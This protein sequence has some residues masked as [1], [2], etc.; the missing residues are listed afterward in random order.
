MAGVPVEDLPHVDEHDVVVHAGVEDVWRAVV[1][2]FS[3]ALTSPQ[4]RAAARVLGCVPA[5]ASGWP[6][7][8]G[9]VPGF[10]VAAAEP[11][12]LLVLRGRHRFSRYGIVVRVEPHTD[13]ARCRLES[14]A[15]F[16]GPHGRA[17]RALVIGSGGHLLAVRRLLR[18]VARDA[19]QQPRT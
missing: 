3:S 1:E 12:R 17:Y 16:P 6:G 15:A 4:A 9:T 13:G 5:D 19:E 14:R 10:A 7:P 11:P 2:S 8:D 18:G